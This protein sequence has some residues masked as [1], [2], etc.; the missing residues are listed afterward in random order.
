MTMSIK[1][2]INCTKDKIE[3]QH[4]HNNIIVL[5]LFIREI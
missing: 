2:N 1:G 5:R 3:L 4:T